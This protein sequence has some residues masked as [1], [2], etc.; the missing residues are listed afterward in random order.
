MGNIQFTYLC[1]DCLE[2]FPGV[3]K[4][5]KPRNVPLTS[6]PVRWWKFPPP[7]NHPNNLDLFKVVGE[8]VPQISWWF[9]TVQS[10]KNHQLNKSK[11]SIAPKRTNSIS[12]WKFGRFHD[13]HS[14]SAH[15]FLPRNKLLMDFSN[16]GC[17]AKSGNSAFQLLEIGLLVYQKITANGGIS[18]RPFHPVDLPIPSGNPQQ[19]GHSLCG[20]PPCL[21][22]WWWVKM[23][24]V[25][26]SELER[27][28]YNI[29]QM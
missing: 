27:F 25:S 24:Q 16:T 21:T 15:P 6:M 4:R 13:L 5:R 11:M 3:F 17:H 10:N 23:E 2:N 29:N 14:T 19:L 9:T 20:F 8:N 22:K 28:A 18:L 1:W 7:G 12:S 26:E